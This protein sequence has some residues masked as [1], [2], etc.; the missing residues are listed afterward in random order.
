MAQLHVNSAALNIR[1]TPC[2]TADNIV[3]ALPFGHP[4]ETTGEADEKRWIAV[5][6][7]WGGKTHVGF[8]NVGYLRKPLSN[9]KEAMLAAA[10]MAWTAKDQTYAMPNGKLGFER[11]TT[12][13]AMPTIGDLICTDRHDLVVAKGMTQIWGLNGD[14]KII[15]YPLLEDGRLD[16]KRGNITAVL[17]SLS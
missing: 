11:Q 16:D 13:V 17:R 12:A 5:T 9:A 10:A 14:L 6:A 2:M 4:L 15:K 3:V 8:V 7:N 1:S